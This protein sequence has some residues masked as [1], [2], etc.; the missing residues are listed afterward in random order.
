MKKYAITFRKQ[1]DNPES[2]SKKVVLAQTRKQAMSKIKEE[3]PNGSVNSII[4][5]SE[6]K[7]RRE[8]MKKMLR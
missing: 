7:E 1:Q 5:I 3:Y 2:F 4:E 6:T 8:Q